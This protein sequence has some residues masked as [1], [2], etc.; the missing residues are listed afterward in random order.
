M[1]P[2]RLIT[3]LNSSLSKEVAKVAHD[4]TA[5]CQAFCPKL[6]THVLDQCLL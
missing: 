4:P 5:V 6:N 2:G 1:N 3:N